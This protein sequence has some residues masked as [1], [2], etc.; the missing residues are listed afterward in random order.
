MRKIST[1]IMAGIVACVIFATGVVG[2]VS[3]NRSSAAIQKEATEKLEAMALQYANYM[4]NEFTKY[5]SAVKTIGDYVGAK[6]DLSKVDDPEYNRELMKEIDPFV[7]QLSV[8]DENIVNFCVA[9][10][11]SDI[12]LFIAS[13]FLGSEKQ[14]Q[15][16]KE[17]YLSW[18]MKDP[19]WIWWYWIQDDLKYQEPYWVKSTYVLELKKNVMTYG[20][21][22]SEGE[23]LIAMAFARVDFK[24]FSDLVSSIKLYDT[25]RA[26]LVDSGQAFA[27]DSEFNINETLTSVGYTEIVDNLAKEVNHGVVEVN[28]L[29]IGYALMDNGYTVLMQAPVDEVTAAAKEIIVYIAVIMVAIC[30][31]SI[32]IAAVLGKRI[33]KPI[34]KVADDLALVQNGDFTGTHYKPYVKNKNETG[35]LAK[36][37]DAVQHNMKDTVGAVH[38]GSGEISDAVS[39]LEKVIVNLADQ[40]SNISAI[41]E[42]LAASMEETAAAAEE[43][44]SSSDH[45]V[46]HVHNM[47]EKNQ[48]GMQAV[49][50]IT[51]RATLL[52]AEALESYQETE[53]LAKISEG[54]LKAAIEESKQVEQIDQLTNAILEI[55]DQTALLSLNA[56]IEAARAGESGKG[57]AVVADEIRKLAE[58]CELTAIQIQKI[59]L[60]VTEAVDNLCDNATEVLGFI[61][62]HVKQTNEKLIDTS[63]R[64]NEDAMNVEEILRQFSAAASSISN[65]IEIIINLFM[66]L[67]DATQEG[68][69]GTTE[70]AMNAEE[71]AVNTGYVREQTEHLKKVSESLEE[72]M[73]R[74]KV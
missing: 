66:N 33:S 53:E 65:E 45:M 54:K 64:Y 12:E 38:S 37:L 68:A 67:K 1:S 60:N 4:N 40:V 13:S 6:A 19:H 10:D 51:H 22:V 24:K 69:K 28:G 23:D 9:M 62:S 61:E 11:P 41:S 48:L 73:Q 7:Q 2:A 29:Y 42:E 39:Q 63:E 71:V 72:T 26:S 15:D 49:K 59:T 46:A 20:Y 16:E 74:F 36:A 14:V 34:R 70:V 18:F 55:A 21:P 8:S 25:G 17:T 43:L 50:D 35:I 32:I 47:N 30:V 31:I 5:E 52:K 44:S 56:S 3:I 57:F 58:N 27:V